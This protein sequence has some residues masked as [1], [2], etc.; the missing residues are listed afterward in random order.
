[1]EKVGRVAINDGEEKF[2]LNFI[3]R[4]ALS[5]FLSDK[6]LHLEGEYND[7]VEGNPNS[8]LDNY[9]DWMSWKVNEILECM[10]SGQETQIQFGNLLLS[11]VEEPK[12][13][14]IFIQSESE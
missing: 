3:N 6:Y 14:K 12:G 8:G 2:I 11:T 5:A 1:M 4:G 7:F 13:P 10:E 9:Q